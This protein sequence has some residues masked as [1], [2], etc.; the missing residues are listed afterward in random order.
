MCSPRRVFFN[1]RTWKF[2]NKSQSHVFQ[3]KFQ[4]NFRFHSKI[5]IDYFEG[6]AGLFCLSVKLFLCMNFWNQLW[7][8]TKL[9]RFSMLFAW[10]SLSWPELVSISLTIT[11]RI[12]FDWATMSLSVTL[13]SCLICC[14]T[15][16]ANFSS[17]FSNLGFNP[18][19]KSR[20]LP[21]SDPFWTM[22]R[23]SSLWA[24]QVLMHFDEIEVS[25]E[26]AL[27]PWYGKF[28]RSRT[29]N[30]SL[31]VKLRLRFES[32]WNLI[33]H[34]WWEGN[35]L[36]FGGDASLE[37]L[38]SSVIAWLRR[39]FTLLG[40][41]S[42]LELLSSSVMGWWLLAFRNILTPEEFTS[43][44][45]SL[46]L[47]SSIF[48]GCSQT[49]SKYFSLSLLTFWSWNALIQICKKVKSQTLAQL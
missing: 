48:T 43:S 24:Y 13:A 1:W 27:K 23:S 3:I 19:P 10:L 39:F 18:L 31:T 32:F 37:S 38:S 41:G 44:I 4:L 30:F 17:R 45:S 7:D 47:T 36:I 49:Y 21:L 16:S 2:S 8:A 26:I 42:L 46:T 28:K 29:S 33:L 15:K 35:F 5:F 11:S 12:L 34:F 40:V 25:L 20:F 22:A 9:F 6:F 14:L